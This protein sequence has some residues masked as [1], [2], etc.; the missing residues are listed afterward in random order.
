MS[1]SCLTPVP[2]VSISVH[3]SPPFHGFEAIKIS[4]ASTL[5]PF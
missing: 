3:S 4:N 1:K 5:E 2:D